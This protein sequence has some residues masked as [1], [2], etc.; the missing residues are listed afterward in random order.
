MS[1][2]F[3]NPP[4][5]TMLSNVPLYMYILIHT[6]VDYPFLWTRLIYF[7]GAA[8]QYPENTF[9]IRFNPY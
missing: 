3:V 1:R 5:L 7:N 8:I 9:A 6:K 4:P 2:H